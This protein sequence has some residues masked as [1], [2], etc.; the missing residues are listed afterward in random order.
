MQRLCNLSRLPF[1]HLQHLVRQVV[2]RIR[3]LSPN[4]IGS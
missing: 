2:E 1:S 3:L 4:T